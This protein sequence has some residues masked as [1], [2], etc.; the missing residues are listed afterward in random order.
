MTETPRHPQVVIKHAGRAATV[1]QGLAA[2][3]FAL[4]RL[5]FETISS[6]EDERTLRAAVI[7]FRTRRDAERFQAIS[8]GSL[9]VP[10]LLDLAEASA[11][12]VEAGYS[13]PGMAGVAFATARIPAVLDA[14]R[15]YGREQKRHAVKKIAEEGKR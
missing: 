14:V 7:G 1:D 8:G 12:S 2:L 6:C 13:V 9:V 11:A 4:W 10:S 3:I 15:R 5:G